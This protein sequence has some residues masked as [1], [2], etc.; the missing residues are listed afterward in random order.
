VTARILVGACT[1]SDHAGF[2]PT[3]VKAA[4]RAQ[5]HALGNDDD[6]NA[7][8]YHALTLHE[9]DPQGTIV[10]PTPEIAE[11]FRVGLVPHRLME[12]YGLTETGRQTISMRCRTSLSVCAIRSLSG[13]PLWIASVAEHCIARRS[14]TA[15]AHRRCRGRA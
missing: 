12:Q 15:F 9:R 11:R 10:L 2:Y 7:K 4:E 6:S 3:T 13:T 1:W 8:L 5:R 14:T